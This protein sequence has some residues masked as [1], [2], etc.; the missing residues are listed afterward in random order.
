MGYV[1]LDYRRLGQVTLSK[2]FEV[3]IGWVGIG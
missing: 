2:V 3:R 1:K